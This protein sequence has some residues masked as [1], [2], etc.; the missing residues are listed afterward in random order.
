MTGIPLILTFLGL[1]VL[2]VIAI[3]KFK[4]HPFLAIMGT[5]ILLGF[6]SDIPLV[7]YAGRYGLPRVVG[8]GFSTIFTGIGIV[9]IF[10]AL[11]GSILEIT[12]GAFKIG[13]MVIKVLGKFSPELSM[14]IMGWIVSI[15]V[16][17][18]SG[19]VIIN[20]VRKSIVKKTNASN[21]G[22]AIGLGAGLYTSHVLVPLTPGPL[23]ASES[24]GLGDNLIL[25]MGVSIVISIPVLIASYLFATYSS[26]RAENKILKNEETI[27]TYEEISKE[28]GKLPSG[29]MSVAPILVPIIAM[30]IGSTA[31]VEHV[32]GATGNLRLFLLFLGTPV[33]ALII[34]FLF[35]VILLFKT[36]KMDKF[37]SLTNDTLKA[38]GPILFITGAGGI[39]GA[40]INNSGIVSF[41]QQSAGALS[42]LGLL[43]PFL[44]AA[45]LKTAQGSS[46][47]AII[48]TANIMVP[49]MATLG[50]ASPIMSALTVMAIG[51]GSMAASHANDSYFWI[52]TNLSDMTP[53]S[54]YKHWTA[55]SVVQAVAAMI[56]IFIFAAIVNFTS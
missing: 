7:D 53:E 36:N 54:G 41:I 19:F 38:L 14:I 8:I 11:I 31:V 48:V 35:A 5:A 46:T 12:G 28:I 34:G 16:F 1:I 52:V 51:A 20:P 45:I 9:I 10:G 30:A 49:L 25:L 26:K 33:V 18:D 23:A 43:F 3:S 17:C 4:L 37:N 56:G 50:L 39:L 44:I 32:I 55:M 27:K 13:D 24:L 47:V 6:A 42:G 15:P 2:M 21:V 22:T 40:V 29:L